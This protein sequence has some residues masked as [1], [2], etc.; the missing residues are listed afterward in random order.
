MFVGCF[1]FY[2]ERWMYLYSVEWVCF[3]FWVWGVYLMSNYRRESS[4]KLPISKAVRHTGS[5]SYRHAKPHVHTS[6]YSFDHKVA[7]GSLCM[8]KEAIKKYVCIVPGPLLS[9]LRPVFVC[10]NIRSCPNT[11]NDNRR[12]PR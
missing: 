8:G 11:P 6:R 7:F 1:N 5:T 3:F 10:Y 9:Q 2:E 4:P 12:P